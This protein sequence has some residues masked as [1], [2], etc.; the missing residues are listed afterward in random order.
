MQLRLARLCLDCEEVHDQQQCPMCASE[1]F[2]YLSRWVPG[3]ERRA[4][5]GQT[6]EGETPSG[7]P[8]SRGRQVAT[9]G[10]VGIGLVGV[11]EWLRRR[12]KQI[13]SAAVSTA[14]E[15]E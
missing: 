14:G 6:G 1:T 13:E 12:R 5:P 10:A 2:A 4:R 8:S 11:A 15:L 7:P 9:Y 3:G